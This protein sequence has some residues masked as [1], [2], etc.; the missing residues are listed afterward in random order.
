MSADLN[1]PA[2]FLSPQVT[3][4]SFWSGLLPV[5]TN[6]TISRDCVPRPL[7][8]E[9][10]SWPLTCSSPMSRA[11]GPAA[12]THS[13]ASS[14]ASFIAP[15]QIMQHPSDYQ[16]DLSTVGSLAFGASAQTP[17]LLHTT[18]PPDSST[19]NS[20]GENG[21]S[22]SL[23]SNSSHSRNKH[24]STY[25]AQE[26]LQN[27]PPLKFKEDKRERHKREHA[28]ER[29]RVAADKCRKKKKEHAKN[30]VSRCETVVR[31][32]TFLQRKVNSLWDEILILKN[33]LLRHSQCRN[34][35]IKRH[36]M[37]MTNQ[38]PGNAN[39]ISGRLEGKEEPVEQTASIKQDQE[40]RSELDDLVSFPA[41]GHSSLAEAQEE[42]ERF[43]D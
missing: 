29:N 39:T 19:S 30:S 1:L 5:V 41:S 14:E 17:L 11:V 36:L 25:D 28:R 43:T 7:I 8:E 24:S 6:S 9:D 38:S 42:T 12:R 2:T 31:E 26:R 18:T 20:S 23:S 22:Q 33:E 10:G 15:C 34:E 27:N 21:G 32:N 4:E 35:G 16:S 40:M 13:T 37:R 3:A